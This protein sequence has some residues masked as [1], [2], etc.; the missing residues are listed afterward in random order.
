MSKPRRPV[1]GWIESDI[2]VAADS[3]TL[4]TIGMAYES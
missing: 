3:N 4:P 2:N 1:C